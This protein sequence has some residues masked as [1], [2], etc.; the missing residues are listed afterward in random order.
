MEIIIIILVLIAI[1]LC[2]MEMY[3][4]VHEN[5]RY[6]KELIRYNKVLQQENKNQDLMIKVL[7]D[8]LKEMEN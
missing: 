6:I 7:L 4:K 1:V 3:D 5:D 8:K 2:M